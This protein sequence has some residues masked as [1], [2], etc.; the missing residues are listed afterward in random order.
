MV[1]D[2]TEVDR[3]PNCEGIWFDRTE[4]GHLLDSQ[5]EAVQPLMK[6]EDT[7]D[8]NRV[9]GACPRDGAKMLRVLSARNN[10]IVIDSCVACK[11]IWLDGG[12]FR[13]IKQAQPQIRLREL[14]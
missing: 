7:D 2:E 11:G 3:C 4:L 10:E 14:V 5:E 6:G 13:R 1:V 9:L 8:K 12:E